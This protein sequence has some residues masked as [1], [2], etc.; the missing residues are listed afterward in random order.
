MKKIIRTAIAI[1]LVS[2]FISSHHV[3]AQEETAAEQGEPQTVSL[4]SEELE[5]ALPFP[6]ILPDN[7]L[8]FVKELRDTLMR[9]FISSPVKRIE[10]SLLQSDKYLAMALSFADTKKWEWAGKVTLQS[11]KEM[12]QAIAE[13][14]SARKSGVVIPRDLV[15]NLERS[16]VKH[17]QRIDEMKIQSQEKAG[18]VFQKASDSFAQLAAQASSLR[19]E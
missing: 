16:T 18:G 7:S 12:E 17:K 6:G 11:Q 2:V 1:V 19:E 3:M 5:Y 13:V 15:V 9:M 10:F 14:V 8:Y 4:I